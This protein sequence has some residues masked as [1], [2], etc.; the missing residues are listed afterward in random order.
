MQYVMQFPDISDPA[1]NRVGAI[2][3]L[4]EITGLGLK[5]AKEL[6]ETGRQENIVARADMPA[7]QLQTALD[8]L[9]RFGV[10][11]TPTNPTGVALLLGEIQ[12]VTARAVEQAEYDLAAALVE[13]LRRFK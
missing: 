9:T 4:R 8:T 10:K 3:A 6:T 13:V 12:Y 2:K 7:D 5:E 1:Y 11:V